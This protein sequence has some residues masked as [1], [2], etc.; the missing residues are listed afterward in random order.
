MKV[1]VVVTA[2]SLT[3]F[4]VLLLPV[5]P[6]PVRMIGF[7]VAYIPGMASSGLCFYYFHKIPDSRYSLLTTSAKSVVGYHM[8]MATGFYMRE[9]A[10]AFFSS[11]LK[12]SW[13]MSPTVSCSWDLTLFLP[14]LATASIAQLQVLRYIMTIMPQTFLELDH[15]FL[16]YP[17]V[18]SI[19]IAASAVIFM[20]YN[21]SGSL[22]DKLGVLMLIQNLE[23]DVDVDDMLFATP[24]PKIVFFSISLLIEGLIRIHMNWKIIV[25]AVTNAVVPLVPVVPV[26]PEVPVI[27]V[28][29]TVPIVPEVTVSNFVT[30]ESVQSTDAVAPVTLVLEPDISEVPV[31][32]QVLE[33]SVRKLMNQE[34]IQSTDALAKVSKIPVVPEAHKVSVRN[35]VTQESV[36]CTDAVVPVLFVLEPKVSGVPV[37]PTVHKVSGRS[38]V[39]QKSVLSAD[40]TAANQ[41]LRTSHTENS[42][43]DSNLYANSPIMILAFI[44][45]TIMALFSLTS[46]VTFFINVLRNFYL[47]V[48]PI[49]WITK[50]EIKEFGKLKYH[51]VKTRF[52]YF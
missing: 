30:Q 13:E 16:A 43:L 5:V 34:S 20:I 52:G 17:L 33:L 11:M 9:F 14:P 47:W 48:L 29:P 19:P 8:L 25:R 22:C 21:L 10:M 27:S 35:F 49:I 32:P 38:I 6:P 7:T 18:A 39:T 44:F 51:Q 36:Q 15:S 45:L 31:V 41:Q 4:R 24:D 37:V 1:S 23:L 2:I 50:Q 26:V 3:A 12:E 40:A 42:E 28:V 46:A